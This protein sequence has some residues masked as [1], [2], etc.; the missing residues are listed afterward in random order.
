MFSLVYYLAVNKSIMERKQEVMKHFIKGAVVVVGITIVMM[1]IH[2]IINIVC[3]KNGIDLNSTAM[4]MVSTFIGAMSGM[5]IYDRW[6][7][8][9]K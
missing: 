8:D 9:E 1:I 3:S 7:K 4:S 2:I 5:F 6:I